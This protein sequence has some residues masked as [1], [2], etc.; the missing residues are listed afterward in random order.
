MKGHIGLVE[1]LLQQPNV[2]ID[3]RVNDNTGMGHG[4]FFFEILE[5]F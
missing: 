3:S 4:D 2:D 1:Y 5:A